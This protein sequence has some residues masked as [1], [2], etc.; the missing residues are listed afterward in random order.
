MDRLMKMLKA[1]FKDIQ[2]KVNRFLSS[3]GIG[4]LGDQPFVSI[5]NAHIHT[6]YKFFV[7][8]STIITIVI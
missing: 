6:H 7:Q 4:G 5:F 2:I 3:E 8:C 1:K